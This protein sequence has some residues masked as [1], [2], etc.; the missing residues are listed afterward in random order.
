MRAE[1]LEKTLSLCP[2]CL[3]TLPAEI[4]ER[5]EDVW[6][7]RVCP[8]H[9]P[10]SLVIWRGE[11]NFRT[12]KRPKEPLK[13]VAQTPKNL[14][15]PFDCGL[16]PE[17]GQNPCTVLLEITQ[18]C[19]LNCPICFANSGASERF[20]PLA[21]L[22]DSLNWLRPNVGP[23]VLQISGGEPTLHPNLP[24]L[25][26]QAAK[27]FPAVQLN[28][29]GLTLAQNPQLAQTLADQGLSWVFLQFDGLDDQIYQ[30]LR[31]RPLMKFK[32]AAIQACQA[33]NLAVV[34]TPTVAKGVNDH[35]L[36]ALVDFARARPIIRG[37]HIQPMTQAGRYHLNGP[38]F[39][40]TIPEILRALNEQTGGLIKPEQAFPPGCEHERCSFH[41]RFRRL[42]DGSLIPRAPKADD[43]GCGPLG[44]S[45]K[46]TTIACPPEETDGNRLKAVDIIIQSWKAD[47]APASDL[48]PEPLEKAQAHPVS[49]DRKKPLELKIPMAKPKSLTLDDFLA[50][51]KRETFSVTGMAFQDAYNMDLAR[52]KGCCVHIY[53]APHRL[54][55]FCAMNLTSANGQSLYRK[56]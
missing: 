51:T 31:G 30:I 14:G 47:A 56:N 27:L 28:T 13:V 26:A 1:L 34:L 29:N 22:V 45:P 37:A 41:L 12:W 24:E 52:L 11:P 43:C 2:V 44:C 55:P 32:L 16:C 3:K 39:R 5:G 42:D 48:C 18:R 38:N 40:L 20:T 17:H 23:V 49:L 19:D 53:Q 35:Q 25:V 54:I 21:E 7:H 6:L 10:F 15:C 33:A 46:T 8:E 50:Q 4:W 36:G 9:G